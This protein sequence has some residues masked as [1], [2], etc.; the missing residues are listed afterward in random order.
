MEKIYTIRDT[1]MGI[2]NQPVTSPNIAVITRDL[3][4]IVNDDKHKFNKYPSDFELFEIG[5]YSKETG[6]IKPCAPKF[7]ITL[8]EL[9]QPKVN[10]VQ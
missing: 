4:E 1:K 3:Q 10:H 5:E 6:E 9:I 8:S 7:Q 2:Y